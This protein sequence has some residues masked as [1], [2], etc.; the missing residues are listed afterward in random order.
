MNKFLFVGS[1]VAILAIV[2]G[3]V[4]LTQ[5]AP[6]ELRQYQRVHLSDLEY[7]EVSFRNEAQGLS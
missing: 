3:P 2:F 6:E 7:T 4:V 1:I 5:L